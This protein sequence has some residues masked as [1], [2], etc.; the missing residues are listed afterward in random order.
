MF[1]N[2]GA[3]NIVASPYRNRNEKKAGKT[4]G[5]RNEGQLHSYCAACLARL[6]TNGSV[7]VIST[8]K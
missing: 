7:C 5:C 2:T 8:L 1:Y 3:G 6:Q 4:N